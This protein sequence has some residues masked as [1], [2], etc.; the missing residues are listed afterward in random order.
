[1]KAWY[2]TNS[3]RKI[4]LVTHPDKPFQF[5]PKGTPR[6]HLILGDYANEIA[7]GYRKKEESSQTNITLPVSWSKKEVLAL[8]R[9]AVRRGMGKDV[10]DEDDIFQ[11][12]C[13]RF[14]CFYALRL[15]SVTN[16]LCL[17]FEGN[18]DQEHS[19]TRA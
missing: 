4:I 8:A 1:M 13:D 5:T 3:T 15:R 10:G 7:E 12:G 16:R 18:L 17:Q 2:V 11:A 19:P 6:R 9:E 14:G